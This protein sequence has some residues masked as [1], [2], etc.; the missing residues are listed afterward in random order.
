MRLNVG[1]LLDLLREI[2]GNFGLSRLEWR[3]L[4]G[5]AYSFQGV[6]EKS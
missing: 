2:G 4:V 5:F 1:H 6:I 3:C